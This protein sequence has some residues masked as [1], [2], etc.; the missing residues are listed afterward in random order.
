MYNGKKQ[1][2]KGLVIEM[3]VADMH[4]DTI[5]E[6][7]AIRRSSGQTASLRQNQ[8][9]IDIAKMRAGDYLLQNFALYVNKE[10]CD[11][12]WEE[13][14]Q[15]WRL[16]EQE[17]QENTDAIGKVLTYADIEENEQNGKLSALLTVEEGGI[18]GGDVSQLHR[19]YDMGVRMV[20]L[21]WNYP[22]E[23]GF[24]NLQGRT[25]QDLYI[26]DTVHG[27]TE[28]GVEFVKEMEYLGIVTDVSHLSDAGFWDVVTHTSRPFVASHSNAREICPCVRNLT[29]D[30]IRTIGERGGIIG[31]NFCAD[32]LT[33]PVQGRSAPGTIESIVKHARHMVNVGG[34]ECVGLGSDF[35]GIPTH[36]ELPAAD[37]MPLL[38]EAL[39]QAG[40]TEG[41]R[42]KLFSQNV[43]R[44]YREFL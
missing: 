39:K 43:L 2:R 10:A 40:F 6:L 26:P 44:V 37:R 31:L 9:H 4:C 29:D 8:L 38:D 1:K 42:E 5:S 15:L 35:D 3:K 13:A 21:T 41:E 19:L 7:L 12:P 36:A 20:T 32:F 14:V 11:N 34:M 22:N 28:K 17:I 24:P 30:M 16:Y 27:L 25:E 33:A 23:L 18:C